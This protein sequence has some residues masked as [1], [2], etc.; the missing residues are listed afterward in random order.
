MYK[1][2]PTVMISNGMQGDAEYNSYQ[3]GQTGVDE[4]CESSDVLP[5]DTGGP[6]E[7]VVGCGNHV[8]QPC[9]DGG[10]DE[11]PQ[12]ED[13]SEVDVI[14]GQV[15]PPTDRGELTEQG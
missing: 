10:D 12:C 3:D 6:C 15:P 7:V 8:D 5:W 14:V 11:L 2:E 9:N 13:P 4:G 1:G